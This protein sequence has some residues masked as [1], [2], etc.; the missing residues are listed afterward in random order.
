[1]IPLMVKTCHL[2]LDFGDMLLVPSDKLEG[3]QYIQFAPL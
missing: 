2:S 1:M 3:A